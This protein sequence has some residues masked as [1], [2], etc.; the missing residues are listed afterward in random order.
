M[1]NRGTIVDAVNVVLG[2][3]ADYLGRQSGC[4]KIKVY[5]LRL[6][7]MAPPKLLDRSTELSVATLVAIPDV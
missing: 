5:G 6:D 3:V 4:I 2:F 1:N 7:N